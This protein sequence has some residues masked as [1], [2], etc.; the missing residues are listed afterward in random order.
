MKVAV[1]LVVPMLLEALNVALLVPTV[2]GVPLIRPLVEICRPTGR[3]EPLKVI[4][5]VPL[6]ATV[7]LNVAPT[8]PLKEFVEVKVGDCPEEK[9]AGSNE[10]ISRW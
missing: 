2:V 3:L 1:W 6:A 10:V 8:V 5:A 7:L 9:I 4:G